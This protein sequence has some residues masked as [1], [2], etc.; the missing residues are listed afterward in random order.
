M[1]QTQNVY[2]SCVAVGGNI[3]QMVKTVQRYLKLYSNCS[4]EKNP[5]ML[6]LIKNIL[7]V[8]LENKI[9][10]SKFKD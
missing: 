4:P 3:L 2:V 9:Q 1:I 7:F 6:R 8:L 5:R 10:L